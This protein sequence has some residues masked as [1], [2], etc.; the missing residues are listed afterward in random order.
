MRCK[1]SVCVVVCGLPVWVHSTALDCQGFG[2][3]CP[4]PPTASLPSSRDPVLILLRWH[5]LMHVHR[6]LGSRLAPVPAPYRSTDVLHALGVH[7]VWQVSCHL[8][9]TSPMDS[10]CLLGHL[11]VLSL[12][13]F[14][15]C[16][17]IGVSSS[18]TFSVTLLAFQLMHWTGELCPML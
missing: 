11:M 14:C 2:L 1:R 8:W 15:F 13:P 10:A 3:I 6:G 16:S 9:Q 5:G 4:V 17:E 7:S 12:S 18:A